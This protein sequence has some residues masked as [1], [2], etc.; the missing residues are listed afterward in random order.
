[1]YL[2]CVI[3]GQTGYVVDD[4]EKTVTNK[5]QM[6]DRLCRSINFMAGGNAG[7]TGCLLYFTDEALSLR[8]WLML[9]L[10]YAV[11]ATALIISFM[12]LLSCAAFYAP[13]AAEA[14]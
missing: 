4:Q 11:S 7:K 6:A 13:A 10:I 5:G 2:Y 14:C 9:L 8:A 12:T 1:M 3:R